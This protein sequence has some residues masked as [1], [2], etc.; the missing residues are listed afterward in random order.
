[1]GGEL[2]DIDDQLFVMGSLVMAM[3]EQ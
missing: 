3:G 2:R 1:M